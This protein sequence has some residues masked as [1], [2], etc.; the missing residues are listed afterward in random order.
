[1]L[2]TLFLLFVLLLTAAGVWF[3][4]LWGNIVTLI[5]M[6]IAAI[7]ATCYYEPA[8]TQILNS[9][10]QNY[11]YIADFLVLWL[12]FA[13][14]FGILRL[15]TDMISPKRIK[16]HPMTELIGRSVLA[17]VIGYVMMMFTAFTIHTAPIQSQPFN[18]ALS[19]GSSSFLGMSPELQ[20]LGFVRGQSKMGLKGG[21]VFDETGVWISQQYERRQALEKEEGFLSP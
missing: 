14:T 16:F 9:T 19:P 8:T 10:S 5:N 21:S 6:L 1:M 3:H 2:L 11:S 18:G 13:F 12:I 7:V 20:W 15:I 17:V 4:G